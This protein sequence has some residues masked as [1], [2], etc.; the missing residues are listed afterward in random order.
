METKKEVQDLIA[1]LSFE[2]LEEVFYGLKEKD[3]FNMMVDNVIMDRMCD[4][5]EARFIKFYEKY[6]AYRRNKNDKIRTVH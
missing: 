4:I 5:D 2:E 1:N 3:T 6:N